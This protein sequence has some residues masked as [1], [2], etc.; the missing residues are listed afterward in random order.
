[1]DIGALLKRGFAVWWRYKVLW[2]LGI[3]LALVGR[4]GY[5]VTVNFGVAEPGQPPDQEAIQILLAFIPDDL[6]PETVT[7]WVLSLALILLVGWLVMLFVGSIVEGAAIVQ[8]DLLDQRSQFDLSS[9]FAAGL[10]RMVPLALMDLLLAVP[11]LVVAIGILILFASLIAS[12]LEVYNSGPAA[13]MLVS[14]IFVILASMICLAIPLSIWGLFLAVF[15]PLAARACVLEGHG[16]VAS[17]KRGWQILR[18]NL[19]QAIIVWLVTLGIG[20]V[21]SLPV[22]AIAASLLLATSA[23]PVTS[24][25]AWLVITVLFNLIFAVILGGLLASLNV[26]LW[27]VGYRQWTT[28]TPAMQQVYAPVRG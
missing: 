25:G 6:T 14:G 4:G 16:P 11:S 12:T 17:I 28:A 13:S 3:L 20:I 2:A 22:G 18:R 26:T 21:Y 8:T 5:G 7:G 9:S 19:G 15:R 1:M 27:T 10:S 23:N 24:F